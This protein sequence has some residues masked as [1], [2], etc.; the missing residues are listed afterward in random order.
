MNEPV[1]SEAEANAAGLLTKRDFMVACQA[2]A[3]THNR[4]LESFQAEEELDDY[5]RE[6][7]EHAIQNTHMTFMKFQ[8][9]LESTEPAEDGEIVEEDAP[10]QDLPEAE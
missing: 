8:A 9:I 2:L 4:Y 1:Q 10:T 7:M 5:S 3:E 6:E